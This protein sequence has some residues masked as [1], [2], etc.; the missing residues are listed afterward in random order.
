MKLVFAM[1]AD[2]ASTSSDGKLSIQGGDIDSVRSAS[3]PS[4]HPTLTLVA[5][6]VA[7]PSDRDKTLALDIAGSTP[8]GETWFQA[9][10]PPIPWK[11]PDKLGRPAKYNVVVNLPMLVF[12][13]EGKYIIR[14]LLGSEEVVSLPLY[15]EQVTPPDAK[16]KTAKKGEG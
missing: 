3:F 1:L 2:S 10:L 16:G 14:L 4:V 9:T 6:L 12:L 7:E 11:K 13:T 15:A 8:Q 5:R